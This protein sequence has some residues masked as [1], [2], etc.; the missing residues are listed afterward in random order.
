VGGRGTINLNKS[1]RRGS[2]SSLINDNNRPPC[3]HPRTAVAK[4]GQQAVGEEGGG[5]VGRAGAGVV[6]QVEEGKS[7]VRGGG[8]SGGGSGGESGGRSQGHG[9]GLSSSTPG[10]R[11]T[12]NNHNAH[13]TAPSTLSMT[14]TTTNSAPL[15]PPQDSAD[16]PS[17]QI[18]VLVNY[19]IL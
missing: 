18:E 3:R 10:G 6:E 8:G 17:T 1:W 16:G 9:C 14:M 5:A 13:S 12:A 11:M 4:A 2:S 19:N 15:P 7:K